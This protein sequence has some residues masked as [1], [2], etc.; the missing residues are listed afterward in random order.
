[1]ARKR[2]RDIQQL[3]GGQRLQR[4]TDFTEQYQRWQQQLQ[5]CFVALQ[6]S[7]LLAHCKVVSVRAHTLVLEVSSAALASRIKLQQSRIITHFQDESTGH[8]SRLD[9]QVRPKIGTPSPQTAEKV[10]Q[11][12]QNASKNDD[13][14]V[15]KL[16]QQAE[17]CEE[18]LRSQ[19]LALAEKYERT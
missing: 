15:A 8:I 13:E 18:P 14:T 2:P 19:L 3:F 5:Q 11:P 17:L 6:L 7:P 10:S 9:V 4:F 16:R 12:V 1:M